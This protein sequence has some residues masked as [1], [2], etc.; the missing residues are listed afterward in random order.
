MHGVATGAITHSLRQGDTAATCASEQ[1]KWQENGGVDRPTTLPTNPLSAGNH[2]SSTQGHPPARP[3][4]LSRPDFPIG[5]LSW[6]GQR[7]P[8]GAVA[9]TRARRTSTQTH[10]HKHQTQPDQWGCARPPIASDRDRRPAG[11]SPISPG[12]VLTGTPA[13]GLT[14][15]RPTPPAGQRGGGGCAR[16]WGPAPNVQARPARR[17]FCRRGRRH[18]RDVAVGLGPPA[19]GTPRHARTPPAPPTFVRRS[20]ARPPCVPVPLPSRTL[21]VASGRLPR[22]WPP[23]V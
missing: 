19:R 15:A 4:G 11:P 18:N 3:E 20:R 5:E 2:A 17:S 21:P 7:A 9:R 23:D 16:F 22:R 12:C 10:T 8:A 13:T 1:I 6:G 14:P